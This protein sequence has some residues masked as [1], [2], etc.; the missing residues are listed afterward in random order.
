MKRSLSLLAVLVAGTLAACG[1]KRIDGTD[2][3]DTGDTRAVLAV[4]DAYRKGAEKR[5]APAVLALV[6]Q[7]YFDDAGTADPA[8]DLD[9]GQLVKALPEDYQK[10]S[11]VKLTIKVRQITVE[12]DKAVAEMLYDGHYRI[13]TPRGDVAKQASD[14]QQM[15][16]QREGN[17]WKIVSGL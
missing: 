16:L 13:A 2:I 3:A 12:G 6:S 10:L 14:V 5:D 9:Y 8:D 15:L 4:I 1:P 17:T 7:S 11:A